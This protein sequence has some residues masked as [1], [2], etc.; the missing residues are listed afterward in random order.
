MDANDTELLERA[1]EGDRRALE[2]LLARHQRSV[3][4]FGLKMCRDEED[5]K[6][7]LQE[8][9]LAV[10]RNVK[11]FRGASSVS[12]W[13]YTI[14]RS[15]CI[16]KRRRSKFAPAQEE[17]LSAREPGE[18]ARQVVDPARAPDDALAGRQIESALEQAIGSLDPMYREVLLLRDV[19]GLTAPEVAE[20]MGLSVEAVKS[21]LHRAR[22]AVREAV[23]PLLG[24]PGAAP[25]PPTPATAATAERCPDIVE[26]FSKHLEGEISATLC[27]DMERHLARCPAC[28]ARC[29]SLQKTLALCK[30]APLPEVPAPVQASIRQA[31]KELVALRS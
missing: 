30:A 3:Y 6:D 24:I 17:S 2:A 7:I 31:M 14:A 29:Q 19:E 27:A 9:L 21:R 20:V 16:K 4:R 5:A 22:V 28:D 15:F 10:A 8:T 26:L 25:A 1:R 12:T 13:L 11:D 18:A 23:A